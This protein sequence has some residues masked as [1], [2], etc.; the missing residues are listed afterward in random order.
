[1]ADE[2]VVD[3]AEG[4]VSV[5][6]AQGGAG[7]LLELIGDIMLRQAMAKERED[8]QAIMDDC[9]ARIKTAMQSMNAPKV[10]CGPWQAQLV[11]Q[12]RTTLSKHKLVE[13]GVEVA[14]I[15]AATAVTV[16]TLLRVV[17]KPEG[18]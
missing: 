18:A 14:T 16:V 3:L 6:G 8:A 2:V 10:Y 1:M 12:E 5:G 15:E 9:S 4:V 17:P 7:F 13:L 11:T